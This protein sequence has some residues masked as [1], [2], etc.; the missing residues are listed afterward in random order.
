MV[1]SKSLRPF[2]A[3]SLCY[4]I[5]SVMDQSLIQ[6]QSLR[7]PLTRSIIRFSITAVAWTK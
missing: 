1:K 3:R 4:R 2:V 5:F 6:D 7:V